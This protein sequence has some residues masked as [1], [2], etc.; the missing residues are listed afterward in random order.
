MSRLPH[1]V[2]AGVLLAAGCASLEPSTATRT[3][4]TGSP[5]GGLSTPSFDPHT[6]Q[7]ST[8]PGRNDL[9]PTTE[10]PS[11]SAEQR[12]CRSGSWPRGWIAVAYEAASGNECP[13]GRGRYPV[14]VLVRYAS[15]PP[16]ATLDVC[17][18]QPTPANW[19]TDDSADEGQCPGAAKDG[20]SATKRIHRVR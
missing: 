10:H 16:N 14:A 19:A 8:D 18:D 12:I 5:R 11:A 7:P 13:Q 2:A 6:R 20:G 9:P 3:G 17:A 1:A 4:A 15:Q